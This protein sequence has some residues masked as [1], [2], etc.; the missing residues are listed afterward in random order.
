MK[1][2]TNIVNDQLVMNLEVCTKLSQ[3]Q[4]KNHI[5][6][7]SR[8]N[9]EFQIMIFEEQRNQ[10]FKLKNS[11]IDLKVISLAAFYLAIKYF[12][13]KEKLLNSK[14]KSQSLEAIGG[15]TKIELVKIKKQKTKQK[16]QT[17]LNL[18]SV[19]EK[20]YHEGYSLREI[21][22]VLQNKYRKNVSHTYVGKFIK[23]HIAKEEQ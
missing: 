10:F 23:D 8:Q 12:Y 5:N 11:N 1:K 19:I 3:E 4:R 16:Q 21:V 22:S 2:E 6:W 20:L 9:V 17:L 7:L 13:E 15:I 18:Y 14:N